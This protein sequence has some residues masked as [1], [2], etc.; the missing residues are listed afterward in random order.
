MTR[1]DYF[2]FLAWVASPHDRIRVKRYCVDLAGG[3]LVAGILLSRII[4][5]S[6]TQ[7]TNTDQTA[8]PAWVEHDGE[9]WLAKGRA[10]WWDECCLTPKQFD[11]ASALLKSRGLIA[12][13]VKRF[14][15][16]PTKH[17]RLCW[18]NFLEAVSP[19]IASSSIRL[20]QRQAKSPWDKQG[21][22]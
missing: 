8:D 14:Q 11:R 15:D 5:Q 22:L 19:L 6:I 16:N 12:T 10:E 17:V 1:Q 13:S 18:D 7:R 4:D 20:P 2:D 21:L 3:D 9:W